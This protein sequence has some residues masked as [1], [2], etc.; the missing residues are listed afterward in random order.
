MELA[1]K[2]KIIIQALASLRAD[3]CEHCVSFDYLSDESKIPVKELPSL[4][5][6]LRAK[7]LVEFNRGLMT[8]DNEVAGSGYC[9]TS[10]GRK[11]VDKLE[12]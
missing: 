9:L 4:M 12:L 11:L 3:Y 10:E 6:S 2:E 5:K 1:P 8:E 7:E